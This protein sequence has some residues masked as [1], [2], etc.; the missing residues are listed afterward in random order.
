MVLTQ[1]FN[2]AGDTWKTPTYFIPSGLFLVWELPL[3]YVLA[4][5]FFHV[6]AARG[7]FL[8]ITIASQTWR[9]LRPFIDFLEQEGVEAEGC[10]EHFF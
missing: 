7:V 4:D 10:R 9:L 3:A 2:G 1:S 8:A 5:S 6:E